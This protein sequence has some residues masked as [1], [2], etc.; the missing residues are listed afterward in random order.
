[1]KWLL[2]RLTEKTTWLGILNALSAMGVV[3][4]EGVIQGIAGAGVGIITLVLV[5]MQEKKS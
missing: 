1:M 2:E 4:S 3:M 5:I